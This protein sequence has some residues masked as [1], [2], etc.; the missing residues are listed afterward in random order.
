MADINL[1][2]STERAA[3]KPSRWSSVHVPYRVEVELDL[4]DAI[5]AKGSALAASDVISVVKLPQDAVVLAASMTVVEAMAGTSTDCAL[6][7]GSTAG[8]AD[9]FVDGFGF[10]EA[11]VDEAA[12]M[13]TANFPVYIPI[14]EE[15]G[16][17]TLDVT[18]AAQTGTVTGGKLRVWALLCSVE[19][20]EDPGIAQLG[21]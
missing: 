14:D 3:L 20:D 9:D 2:N 12:D 4:A 5:A 8:G 11:G 19:A 1:V 17:Y 10:F 18:I 16:D 7:L 15:S 6:D 21:S 13:V